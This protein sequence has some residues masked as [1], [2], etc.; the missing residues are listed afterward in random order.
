MT[1]QEIDILPEKERELSQYLGNDHYNFNCR[2]DINKQL[3]LLEVEGVPKYADLLETNV[4]HQIDNLI[5]VISQRYG[6][7]K[8][9]NSYPLLRDYHAGSIIWVREWT[10]GDKIIKVGASEESGGLKYKAVCWIY[11]K[12][13]YDAYLSKV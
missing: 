5:G 8:Y 11:D 4:K 7:P 13:M 1:E 12:P 2:Y 10:V 6:M 9:L 3:Y